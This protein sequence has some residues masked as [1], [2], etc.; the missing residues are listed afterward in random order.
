MDKC[1]IRKD[2]KVIFD[3]F[4]DISSETGRNRSLF[5]RGGREEI[6][7]HKPS[8]YHAMLREG[9]LTHVAGLSTMGET[10]SGLARQLNQPL[11][12][13]ADCSKASL[14]PRRAPPFNLPYR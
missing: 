14:A 8:Q 5:P 3:H 13:S 4:R 9:E 7:E 2:G 10:V 12:A 6:T 11:C 1:F